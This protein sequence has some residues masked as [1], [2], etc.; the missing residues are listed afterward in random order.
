MNF[1]GNKPYGFQIAEI[2]VISN[3]VKEPV[4]DES[5]TPGDENEPTT[6][7]DGNESTTPGDENEPTTPVKDVSGNPEETTTPEV[8]VEKPAAPEGLAV[9]EEL[10]Y[11]FSWATS[12]DADSYNVYVN[13]EYVASTVETS[14]SLPVS[15]FVEAG[16]YEIAVTAVNAGGESEKSTVTYTAEG[17]G[18]FDVTAT[19]ENGK[20]IANWTDVEGAT[21]YST[22]VGSIADGNEAKAENGTVF[23]KFPQIWADFVTTKDDSVTFD[24]EHNYKIIVV[25][26]AE[27]GE[28]II[29]IGETTIVNKEEPSTEIT[30]DESGTTG[31][32]NNPTTGED[33]PTSG[34]DIDNPTTGEDEP[35]SGDDIDNPTTGENEPTSREDIDNPTT[36]ENEP[37]SGEDIDNPTTGE[38]EPTSGEDIDNP[39]TGDNEE[40][41]N[42]VK[43]DKN[44][45]LAGVEWEGYIGSDWTWAYGEVSQE[46]GVITAEMTR[47]GGGWSDAVWGVQVKAND[48]AVA[49]GTEYT[50]S[51]TLLS[52]ENKTIRIKVGYAD[53]SEILID[54]VELKANEPY[55]YTTVFTPEQDKVKIIYALGASDGEDSDLAYTL[56]ISENVLVSNVEETTTGDVENPTTGDADETTTAPTGTTPSATT[57]APTTAAPTTVATTTTTAKVN[58]AKTKVKK[59]TK[60]LASKKA[61]ISLKKISGAKYQIK[62]SSS[63]KFTKKTTVTK[64]V[65][66]AT[67]TINNKKIKNKKTLYVKAR[68]YKVVGGKTYYGKWSKVKKVK[69]KK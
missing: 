35:T 6:P 40:T 16:E 19:L 47:A 34:E 2:A 24:K 61:K 37:T 25:A 58:V 54:T 39:T 33:K 65:K 29:A 63:K 38:N 42:P 17:I 30:T 27:D 56:T 4:T 15:Y 44:N 1:S 49:A 14:I 28:A 67:F 53:D 11:T 10:S 5:T 68:A 64:K 69:I 32:I 9:S 22:Y 26:Y 18:T 12:E 66:K 50:Y 45:L 60:K 8:V 13:G 21:L 57:V 3:D 23:A 41:T 52:T 59:V 36:G 43:D 55:E 31:D 62:V 7:G 46:D 51:A 48:I 20:V